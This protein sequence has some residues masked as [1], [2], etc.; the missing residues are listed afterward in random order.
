MSPARKKT[1]KIVKRKVRK[2]EVRSLGASRTI[3]FIDAVKL[4]FQ[5][6]KKLL[7][8]ML[9]L[10]IPIVSF[11]V[12][13]YFLKCAKKAMN[14]KFKL[15][16]WEGWWDLFVKGFLAR[17]I[18]FIYFLPAV[19]VFFYVFGTSM[20]ELVIRLADTELVTDVAANQ[21]LTTLFSNIGGLVF[22]CVLCTLAWYLAP[23]AILNFVKKNKF[24]SAFSLAAVFNKAFSMKYFNAWVLVVVYSLAVIIVFSMIPIVGGVFGTFIAGVTF[25]TLLGN[26]YSKIK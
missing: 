25:Y 22:A 26:V 7:I 4:P 11:I 6:I 21:I 17:V 24:L 18:A 12:R 1:K 9:L 23:M 20:I 16:E 10:F 19:I 5:D 3:S 14:Y 2:K 15:P 13:G 8:G